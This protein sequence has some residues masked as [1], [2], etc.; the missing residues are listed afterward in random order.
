MDNKYICEHCNYVTRRTNDL[1]KHKL[2]KTHIMNIKKND[3]DSDSG[4]S[5]G[6]IQWSQNDSSSH[7]DHCEKIILEKPIK[8]IFKQKK[9]KFICNKCGLGFTDKSNMYRHR[10]LYCEGTPII[11]NNNNKDIDELKKRYEKLEE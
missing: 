8:T 6:P 1:K 2:T 9:Q 11:K 3:S 5:S 7:S 10:R 4:H